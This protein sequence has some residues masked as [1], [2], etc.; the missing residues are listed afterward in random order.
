MRCGVSSLCRVEGGCDQGKHSRPGP[1]R[2]CLARPLWPANTFHMDKPYLRSHAVLCRVAAGLTVA[3]CVA[4]GLARGAAAFTRAQALDGARVYDE[5]CAHCHEADGEGKDNTFNGLR[6][7]E[8]MG[9][10]ALPCKPRAFQQLRHQPFRTARDV[11]AFVST[12]MP[13]DRPGRLAP[14][15]YWDVLAYLLKKNDHVPDDTL[16]NDASSAQIVLHPDCPPAR[17]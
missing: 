17:E 11:Y 3:G 13:A 2:W 6:S 10:T 4:L 5:E 16:L 1:V 15:A 12:T 14:E 7:P 9:P 8:V